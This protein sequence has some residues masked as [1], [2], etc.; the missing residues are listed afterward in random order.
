MSRQLLSPSSVSVLFADLCG[1]TTF[2]ERV[3]ASQLVDLLDDIFSAFDHLAN[4]YG[5]EKIKTIGDAY[6]AVAG[7]PEARGQCRSGSRYGT[8]MPEAFSGCNR[9]FQWKFVLA[10]IL[11]VVAGVIGNTNFPTIYGDI[12]N[13]ASRMESHLRA[14]SSTCVPSN[15]YIAQRSLP[16]YRS[17]RCKSREKVCN[18]PIFFLVVTKIHPRPYA[19]SGILR[20]A[21]HAGKH[22]T[23]RVLFGFTEAETRI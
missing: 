9:G 2:S 12:V 20:T 4:A 3:D 11:V 10:S 6:M 7:L 21:N 1:F 18:R 22:K 17:R 13:T 5:V 23:L 8:G 19:G 16:L 15:T 14:I